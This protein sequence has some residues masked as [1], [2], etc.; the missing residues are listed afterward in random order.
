MG[1]LDKALETMQ[2][3][4]GGTINT[5]LIESALMKIG[6]GYNPGL[7]SRIRERPDRWRQLLALEDK[8]NEIALSKD[9]E[10]T[11]RCAL[12]D[13]MEFLQDQFNDGI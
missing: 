10:I 13:Y 11:L 5:D 3:Q 2:K 9:D 8:I 7:I 6:R 4:G 1:Y 12:S